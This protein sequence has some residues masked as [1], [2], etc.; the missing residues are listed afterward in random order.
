MQRWRIP[1][2]KAS[3]RRSATSRRATVRNAVV[4][5]VAG[6]DPV[7]V[8]DVLDETPR[9]EPGRHRLVLGHQRHRGVDSAVLSRIAPVDAHHPL[10]DA[11]EAGDR[12]HQ[13]RLAGAVRSEQ[14]G[15]ARAERAAQLRQGDLRPEP[16]RHVGD[17][18]G[19]VGRE[20]RIVRGVPR[21]RRR[22]VNIGGGC[23]VRRLETAHCVPRP[24]R[25]LAA[26]RR[27]APRRSHRR[28]YLTRLLTARPIDNAGAA[29]RS[30]R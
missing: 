8:G 29:R 25:P 1:L 4:G 9:A 23:R 20:R 27:R 11:D 12:P 28:R 7:Q 10:V 2:L 13:R 5:R 15:D 26:A 18:D 22:G 30:R 14:A 21:P 17:L 19:G 16:H 6:G 3:T 24:R